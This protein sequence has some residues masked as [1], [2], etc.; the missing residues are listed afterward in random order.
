M[1]TVHLGVSVTMDQWRKPDVHLFYD[2]TKG[3]VDIV[4]QISLHQTQVKT[5]ANKCFCIYTRYSMY[6]CQSAFGG[7]KRTQK[8]TYH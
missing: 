4:D 2:N 6:Q 3:G 5:M 8:I 1:P 7:I